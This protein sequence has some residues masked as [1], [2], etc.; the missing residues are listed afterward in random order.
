MDDDMDDLGRLVRGQAEQ[1]AARGDVLFVRELGVRLAERH[2]AAGERMRAYESQLALVVRILALTPGR[3]SLE[4]LLRLLGERNMAG[5][6]VMPRFVASLMAEHQRVADLAAVV[7]DRGE[8]DRLDDLR[9][10]LVHELVLRGVDVDTFHEVRS[11]LRGRPG[12]HP[13]AWLPVGRR[14]LEV[15][16]G[17]PTRGMDNSASGGSTG[18]PAEGR[19]DP[20]TPRTAE[21]SALRDI[22]TI[23]VYETIVAAAQAGGWGDCAAWVFLPDEP[24]AP[25]RVPALLPTLPMPCVDVGPTG[26]FEI[27]VR[28]VDAIWRLLFGVA[29]MGGMGGSG[30]HGAYGRLWAWK[31]MAGLCG[32]PANASWEEVER[33]A[34]Q[35]AWY[36]FEADA[37]WFRNDIHA[38]FGIAAL[39][40][41][42][43]RI[44][45]LAATDTD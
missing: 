44:A 33:R 41:D 42:G 25:D 26:R 13:L 3:D 9:A 18:V 14:D 23:D 7:F 6:G 34:R 31:S 38:D 21:R 4:Q 43:R 11:W 35:T 37:E 8:R 24:V 20:P 39:S 2:A 30:V 29:S 5:R 16:V 15:G 22:A 32:A 1:R 10:C 36:H 17:F 12:W 40:P 28:P 45:V 19:M 27:A